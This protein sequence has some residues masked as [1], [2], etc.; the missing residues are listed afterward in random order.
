MREARNEKNVLDDEWNLF[1]K[2]SVEFISVNDLRI[3]LEL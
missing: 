1:R 2:N 3:E